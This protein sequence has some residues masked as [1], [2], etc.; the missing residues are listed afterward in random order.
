MGFCFGV[1]RLDFR[2]LCL[3][4][5][6][7]IQSLVPVLYF[8]VFMVIAF[9]FVCFGSSLGVSGF[10]YC[11]SFL[12]SLLVSTLFSLVQLSLSLSF[13]SPRISPFMFS[14]S[15]FQKWLVV[16]FLFYFDRCLS[17]SL[18]S[19]VSDPNQHSVYLC[20]FPLLMCLPFADLFAFVD[21]VLIWTSFHWP[22][23]H[24]I[25]WGFLTSASYMW[26]LI[27][28]HCDTCV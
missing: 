7:F 3:L 1:Y 10:F 15:L 12:L 22:S 5:I 9:C 11:Y 27:P 14:L 28:A 6:I 20:I 26:V 18:S 13:C 23:K 4:F 8:K 21:F 24:A 16:P 2:F 25:C 17:V 19:P